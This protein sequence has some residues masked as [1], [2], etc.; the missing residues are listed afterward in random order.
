MSNKGKTFT[1]ADLPRF[2]QQRI[3][4][5]QVSEDELKRIDQ[6]LA[7]QTERYK[8]VAV[9]GNCTKLIAEELAERAIRF[10]ASEERGEIDTQVL[11]QLRNM[12]TLTPDQRACVC[13]AFINDNDEM[14]DLVIPF[15]EPE[16]TLPAK[17]PKK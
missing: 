14:G 9:T 2:T 1:H 15:D 17:K 5:K 6:W 13:N 10:W 8:V 11:V 12:M 3:K 4:N 7:D 16:P